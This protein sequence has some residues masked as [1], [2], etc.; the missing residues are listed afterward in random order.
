MLAQ[1]AASDLLL[2]GTKEK[3]YLFRRAI[4]CNKRKCQ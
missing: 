4:K 3:E 2:Q 1:V